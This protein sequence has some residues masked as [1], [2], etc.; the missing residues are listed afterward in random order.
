MA[1][2]TSGSMVK[3]SSLIIQGLEVVIPLLPEQAAITEILDTMDDVVRETERIV[4][5]LEAMRVGILV[6]LVCPW[7]RQAQNCLPNLKAAS[8]LML[9]GN[10]QL[11][12]RWE[13]WRLGDLAEVDRGKFT[14]RP[15]N[16]PKLFGGTHPFIQTGD[17]V[18]AL[19]K[20]INTAG[21][22][23]TEMGI[24]F[25]REFPAGTIAVTIAA[26]IADTAIL[27]I[28]MF[29]PDS[30]VGVVVPKPNNNR[31]VELCIRVAKHGLEAR[32]PQSAQKN[33]NLQDLRPLRI[34]MPPPEDQERIA[35]EYEDHESKIRAEAAKLNKLRTIKF[36]LSSDLLTGRVRIRPR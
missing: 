3:I 33:I 4:A 5:K 35:M 30:V 1:N 8:N 2:G 23:L 20:E 29:F 34:P 26:N 25:S 13:W 28:P 31:F 11:P 6:R 9:S 15:R 36:G 18:K 10:C 27:G 16:E 7:Q 14:H 17:V 19:G 12:P 32:A 24:R 21:Q 22:W